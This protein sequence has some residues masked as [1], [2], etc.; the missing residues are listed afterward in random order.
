[1]AEYEATGEPNF[2]LIE[3][4]DENIEKR[5]RQKFGITLDTLID[6]LTDNVEEPD[7]A[8]ETAT[9]FRMVI[10]TVLNLFP[11]TLEAL[12]EAILTMTASAQGNIE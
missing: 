5:L 4:T 1:M 6:E 9:M 11:A 7:A 12:I 3:P 8:E 2:T 10:P